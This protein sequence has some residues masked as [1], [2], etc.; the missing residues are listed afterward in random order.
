MSF[1][2]GIHP[3]R[4]DV[5]RLSC[6]VWRSRRTGPDWIATRAG[7]RHSFGPMATKRPYSSDIEKRPVRGVA[8]F[9]EST[10]FLWSGRPDSN[11][12]HSAW[13]LLG[14]KPRI[15]DLTKTAYSLP[16]F[17]PSIRSVH[18]LGHCY[19]KGSCSGG[20]YDISRGFRV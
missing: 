15:F 18:R 16:R 2:R 7:Y 13:K 11:R 12:R 1:S 5:G 10:G 9:R 6:A 19:L 14:P 20:N 3:R 17:L 4:A 8:I